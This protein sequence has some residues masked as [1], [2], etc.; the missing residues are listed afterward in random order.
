VLAAMVVAGGTGTGTGITM[1]ITDTS[2][3]GLTWTLRAVSNS[4]DNF[5]PAWIYTATMPGAGT[6]ATRAAG[7][8]AA[9]NASIVTSTI[10]VGPRYAGTGTDL[11]GVYGSWGTPQFATGGP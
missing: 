10:T 1:T 6:P 5:Q 7:T 4:G 2:G 8:G 11:G 9:L 3:L